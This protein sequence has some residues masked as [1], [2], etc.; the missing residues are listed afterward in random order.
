MFNCERD[1]Q[2]KTILALCTG[3]KIYTRE[4]IKMC[5]IVYLGMSIKKI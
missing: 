1:R 3:P 5:E 4:N 2:C